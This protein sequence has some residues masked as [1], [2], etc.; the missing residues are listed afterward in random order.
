MFASFDPV[1]LDQACIDAVNAANPLPGSLLTDRIEED[2]DTHDHF[3]T[4]FR[5]T[6]WQEGPEARRA[7]RPRHDEV[8]TCFS[9]LTLHTARRASPPVLISENPLGEQARPAVRPDGFARKKADGNF[10]DNCLKVLP[11]LAICLNANLLKHFRRLL[12]LIDGTN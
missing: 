2:G 11:F 8:R 4:I 12:R 5:N 6:H 10:S 7:H 9:R 3:H 1:A